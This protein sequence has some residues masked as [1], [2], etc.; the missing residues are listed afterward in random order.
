MKKVSPSLGKVTAIIGAQWG[1]EGK[2]KLIDLLAPDFDVTARA[3]G[4]AN[5]GHTIVL[6]G[7]K[8]VFHLIPSGSLHKGKTVFLGSGMV[9]HLPTLLEEI[10]TLKTAGIDIIPQLRISRAAHIVFNFHKDIDGTL[11]DWRAKSAGDTLGT[12][13]RGIGP[14]YMEKAARTGL[15]MEELEGEWDERTLRSAL[16]R[17]REA[18][19]RMYGV[20]VNIEE[21]LKTLK[22]A[23]GL[24]QKCIVPMRDLLTLF[25][26]KKRILIE[27]A[28]ATLLDIDHGT[29]PFVTSSQTTAAG[30]LQGLGLPPRA[31]QSCIGVVKAYC[32]RVGGG[33]FPTEAEGKRGDRLRERGGEYGAT[34][35]RPRR[36]GWLSIPD[37][38]FAASLNG[39]THL[40]LTKLD[41]LDEEDV[42]P[43]FFRNG[44]RN[45]PGWKTQ[46][47]GITTFTKLPKSA[48]MY[49]RM[50]EKETGIPVS[51]I[52]TGPDRKEMIR[53]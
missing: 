16:E 9:I 34:T 49:V 22:A 20:E 50:I 29:Y 44:F 4:G 26:R 6:R 18:A 25:E 8:H 51:F 43:V 33:P 45:L 41:V 11:E 32:T 17:S 23:H 28:Q 27:G 2:G 36:C 37:L 5:A 19:N 15:R 35:G 38:Q 13:K 42:I 40:N 53:R 1:D 46:T 14:A 12:T 10:Q 3:S 47:K 30:A 7:K 39:F 52:G 21:E 48:K 31:L 24:L